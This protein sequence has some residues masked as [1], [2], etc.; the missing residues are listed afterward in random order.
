ML[1]RELESLSEPILD[2][3][4]QLGLPDALLPGMLKESGSTV[5]AS[6]H[7]S[8]AP[9]GSAACHAR[10]LEAACQDETYIV[11]TSALLPQLPGTASSSAEE[12]RE[13]TI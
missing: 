9:H 1:C 12:T 11:S 6:V 4:S 3:S 13:A 10:E 7:P 8:R 2:L 5:K